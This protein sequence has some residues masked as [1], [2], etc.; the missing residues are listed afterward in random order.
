MFA[1]T[2]AP[3]IR[4][5]GVDDG[6]A[7][8]A[9][10]A[11]AFAFPWPQGDIETLLLERTTVADGAFGSKTDDLQGFILCRLAADEA[12]ILTIAVA[13]R[14]RRKGLAGR[15]MTASI[16]RL[17]TLGAKSLFLEVEAENTAARALYKR[18]GFATVGERK[19]YYRKADGT[20]AL[21]YILRRTIV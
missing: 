7:C 10:H 13:P 19:S 3:Q 6:A 9:L 15:L 14:K 12:E 16:A 5:L 20:P 8:A 17:S 4:R 11:S 2:F 21:A 18:F 1:K